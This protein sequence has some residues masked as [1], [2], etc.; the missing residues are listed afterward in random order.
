MFEEVEGCVPKQALS[1]EDDFMTMFKKVNKS[2][3]KRRQ[4]CMCHQQHCPILGD[5]AAVDYGCAGLPCWDY[6][7]AGHRRR[8]EGET[9]KVFIAYAAYHCSQRTPLLLIENVKA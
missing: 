7:F 2:K 8:E 6:S 5:D 9:R 1:S 3:L 4:W